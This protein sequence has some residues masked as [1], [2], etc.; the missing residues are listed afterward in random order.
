SW[1][2]FRKPPAT[3]Q[4]TEAIALA[5]TP[6]SPNAYRPDRFPPAAQTHCQQL[7]VQLRQ[8]G[9]LSEDD[10]WFIDC[11]RPP[12]QLRPLLHAAPHL[13]ARLHTGAGSDARLVL[14]DTT[15]ARTHGYAVR[16]TID[17]NVQRR[18][19][20]TTTSYLR[21]IRAQGIRHAAVLVIEN[22]S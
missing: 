2:Y 17:L 16:T 3:L 12:G 18:V 6:K 5:I 1:L 21:E 11:T 15:T 13:L 4:W 9:K 14:Q 10:W 19:E 7:A 8:H 20:Q 22:A